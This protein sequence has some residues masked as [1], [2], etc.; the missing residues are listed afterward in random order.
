MLTSWLYAD[1][2]SCDVLMECTE[3]EGIVDTRDG[4]SY[5]A[6]FLCPECQNLWR[7]TT[8]IRNSMEQIDESS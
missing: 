3:D 6:I 7:Q 1:C 5:G 8:G 2:P 4:F